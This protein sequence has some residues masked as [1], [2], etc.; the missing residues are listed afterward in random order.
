MERA[1]L[2]LSL[3]GTLITLAVVLV[4]V[5]R[6]HLR[7]RRIRRR[8]AT[9]ISACRAGMDVKIVGRVVPIS[10]IDAPFSGQR[11]VAY[12]VTAWPRERELATRSGM[13]A[14]RVDD[15][16]GQIIVTRERDALVELVQ[17]HHRRFMFMF[18]HESA[19]VLAELGFDHAER[20][21]EGIVEPGERVA[22]FGR[23]TGGRD[24]LRLG[25]GA[26]ALHVTDD[27]ALIG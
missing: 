17:E 21:H 6:W 27:P 13:T 15:G 19:P 10:L 5:A 16:T 25:R 23:V 1:L 2:T 20:I 4:F 7:K 8:P 9:P 12:S 14:F 24:G 3:A 18:D 11:C 26:G 22:V